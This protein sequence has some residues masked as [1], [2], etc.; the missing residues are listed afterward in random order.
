MKYCV[1]FGTGSIAKKHAKILNHKGFKCIAVS[2]FKKKDEIF[3][4]IINYKEFHKYDP[5]FWLV[6]F[7]TSLH[8]KVC[9]D[10]INKSSNKNPIYCEKPGPNLKINTNRINVLYNLRYLKILKK[11]K[12]NK[13]NFFHFIHKANAKKWPSN[14]N[15]KNRYVFL[16]K[17]GG[18]AL[19]TNSHELDLYYFLTGNKNV[20]VKKK[21]M[22]DKN[23]QKIDYYFEAFSKKNDLKI[24]SSIVEKNTIRYFKVF[25]KLSKKTKINY[26]FY[27]RS[28]KIKIDINLI[29]KTYVDMWNSLLK[30]KNVLIPKA[31]ETNWIL[32]L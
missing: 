28:K 4:K 10:I 23:G 17:L 22:K 15:W 32:N 12:K 3:H 1:I 30:K 27:D 7:P 6:C 24:E 13:N 19:K 18:G 11:L 21:Y 8:K 31:H 16:K 29:Q 26:I 2:R 25:N 5:M 9:L 20:N 14:V